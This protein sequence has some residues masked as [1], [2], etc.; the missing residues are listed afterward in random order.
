MRCTTYRVAGTLRGPIWWP[1]GQTAEKT[2]EWTG[3]DRP[4]S[5]REIADAVMAREDG[6]F[7][8]APIVLGDTFLTVTR[9]REDGFGHTSRSWSVD[10]FPSIADYTTAD[11]PMR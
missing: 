3:V 4:D 2:F 9:Y 1:L 11:M 10:R 7:S 5:L 8:A 6:D